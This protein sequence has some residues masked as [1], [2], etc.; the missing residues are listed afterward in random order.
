MS[1]NQTKNIDLFTS[2]CSFDFTS[3][4]VRLYVTSSGDQ[5]VVSASTGI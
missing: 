3:F 4:F 5:C 2:H 1:K